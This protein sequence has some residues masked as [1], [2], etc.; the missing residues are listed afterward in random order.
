MQTKRPISKS[1]FRVS[2]DLEELLSQRPGGAEIEAHL[3][4]TLHRSIGPS[5]RRRRRPEDGREVGDVDVDEEH[6][7]DAPDDDQDRAEVA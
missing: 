4:Q 1:I 7:A 6:G 3:E 2:R 5:L